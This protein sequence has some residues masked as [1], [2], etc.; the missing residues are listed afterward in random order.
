MA[1]RQKRLNTATN[2]KTKIVLWQ[3]Q[4][5]F[6]SVVFHFI[7][8]CDWDGAM[9]K[10]TPQAEYDNTCNKNEKALSINSN[11]KKEGT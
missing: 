1:K 3:W 10:E 9:V 11:T 2:V 6:S 4:V 7:A 5:R 8:N